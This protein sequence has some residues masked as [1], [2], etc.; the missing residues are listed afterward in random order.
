MQRNLTFFFSGL[1]LF[2]V[3]MLSAQIYLSNASFEGEYQDATVP[4]SWHTC[5]RGST[6]DILPNVWGVYTEASEGDSFVG[7]IT[8]D[9]GTFES[10]GQRLSSSLKKETCYAFSLDLAFSKTYSGFNEPIKL[11][12]WGG[13]TKCG[14]RQLLLETDFVDHTDWKK[15]KVSFFTKQ[16]IRY[17]IFEAY[18]M[19]E[20]TPRRGNILL[21]NVS[22]IKKCDKA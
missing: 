11:R 3:Q 7:L 13:K 6:P 20:P 19:D 9:D 10:I 18:Y 4:V 2:F 8:R 21:D 15:Y 22:V 14:N 17:L 5:A 1:L 12:V 16:K